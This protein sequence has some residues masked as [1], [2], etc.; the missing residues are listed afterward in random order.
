MALM[1][2]STLVSFFVTISFFFSIESYTYVFTSFWILSS[3]SLILQVMSFCDLP[4][5]NFRNIYTQMLW[6]NEEKKVCWKFRMYI[7]LVS[8]IHHYSQSYASF[9]RLQKALH[10]TRKKKKE[11]DCEKRQFWFAPMSSFNGLQ[12]SVNGIIY[13]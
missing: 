11:H 4:G 8:V 13:L 7:L 5:Q 3:V 9:W 1:L 6:E 2:I 10:F 12:D